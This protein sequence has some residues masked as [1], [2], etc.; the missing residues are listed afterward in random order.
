VVT[1]HDGRAEARGRPGLKSLARS[2]LPITSCSARG[3]RRNVIAVALARTLL[4]TL[5]LSC[6]RIRVTRLNHRTRRR[7]ISARV[8]R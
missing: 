5:R 1:Y 4:A 6:L 3:D 8:T 2:D 7:A